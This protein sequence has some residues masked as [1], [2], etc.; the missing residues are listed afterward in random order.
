MF[1]QSHWNN[2]HILQGPCANKFAKF[3]FDFYIV[4]SD[5][6]RLWDEEILLCCSSVNDVMISRVS[7]FGGVFS[8]VC[9][10][11]VVFQVHR[12]CATGQVRL[13]ASRECVSSSLHSCNFTCGPHGGTLDVEMGM[14]ALLS[15]SALHTRKSAS[16][17]VKTYKT[18]RKV[19]YS[20]G[21]ITSNS[22]IVFS[23]FYLIYLIVLPQLRVQAIRVYW[24]ALQH[25]LPLSTASALC[26]ALAWWT[27]AAQP[28]RKK[29][30]GLGKGKFV[31]GSSAF[32]KLIVSYI[33]Q[34]D[35]IFIHRVVTD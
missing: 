6:I 15:F 7:V 34:A 24:G 12:R 23:C 5:I 14:W 30:P 22:L 2:P 4:I 16:L 28:E 32:H 35:A 33:L 13:A 10:C 29:Q 26:S 8:D 9:L 20:Q 1:L 19:K 27:T 11:V 31:R 18:R 21:V 3:C 17:P 25:F